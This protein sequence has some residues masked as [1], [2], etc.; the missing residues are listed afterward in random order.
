MEG[1]IRRRFGEDSRGVQVLFTKF[2]TPRR[3]RAWILTELL[4]HQG[5]RAALNFLNKVRA[6]ALNVCNKDG[7]HTTEDGIRVDTLMRIRGL[8]EECAIGRVGEEEGRVGEK[9]ERRTGEGGA[10]I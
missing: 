8:G 10:E 3:Y 1:I 5:V 7:E 4:I 6:W 2:N 9:E